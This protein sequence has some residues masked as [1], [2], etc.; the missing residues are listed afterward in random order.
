MTD[1]TTPPPAGGNGGTAPPP[2][3]ASIQDADAR[4]FVELKGWDSPEKAVASYRSLEK[5]IGVPAE[6]VLKLPEK[7]DD[8][9]WADVHK[10]LGMAAPDKPEDY[11]LPVP[12]GFRDDYAK[13]VAAKAKELGIP[14][15]M[16]KGMA[17]WQNG[18]VKQQIE[19]EEKATEMRVNQSLAELRMEWGSAHDETMALAKRAEEQVKATAGLDDASLLAWQNADPKGYFKLMGVIGSKMGEGRMIA[20]GSNGQDAPMSPEAA[21]VRRAELMGDADF[22]KRYLAGDAQANAEMTRLNTIIVGAG[23]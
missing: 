2:W 9:A 4:G 14:K 23:R 22:A 18:F 6:R 8:P 10:R 11:E 20:G 5:M 3:H 7:P 16:L 12:E 21:H 13:A 17:E 15:H 19:A 1:Q